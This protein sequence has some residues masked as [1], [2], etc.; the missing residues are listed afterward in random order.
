[1]DAMK[2][3]FAMWDEES[4]LKANSLYTLLLSMYLRESGRN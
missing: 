2:G 1:M 4:Y 3:P